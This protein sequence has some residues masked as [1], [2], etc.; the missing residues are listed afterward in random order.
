MLEARFSCSKFGARADFTHV[1]FK[2]VVRFDDAK[3]GDLTSFTDAR[4]LGEATFSVRDVDKANPKFQ[5]I[6]F[7]NASFFGPCSFENRKFTANA[8]FND[9]EFHDL[10]K[11]HGCTFHQG[12]SF[13]G[14]KFLKTKGDSKD[15]DELN[16]QTGRLEQAYRTLKLGMETLRARNEEAYF[17]AKEMECR[18]QRSDVPWF[19]R[20]VA[21]PIYKGLSNYGQNVFRPLV[22]LLALTLFSFLFYRDFGAIPGA[23]FR[24][25]T[26]VFSF[27]LEQTFKPFTILSIQ[28]EDGKTDCTKATGRKFVHCYPLIIPFLASGQSLATL[29]LLALFLLA[30]R[31]RFKMD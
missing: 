23:P 5:R 14:T 8:S 25:Q 7:S 6:N 28:M 20:L 17:F 13:H 22:L 27:T 2:N 16:K 24:N 31:R 29:G 11:F 21:A 10:A 15:K 9:A 18:R 26:E 30:L 3:L 1:T 4:F 19:E 12:M